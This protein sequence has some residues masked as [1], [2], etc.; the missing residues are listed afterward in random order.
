MREI[1][2]GKVARNGPLEH[3]NRG[4]S[5]ERV[6]EPQPAPEPEPEPVLAPG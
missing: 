4:Q 1:L 5:P 3:E 2:G 6:Q